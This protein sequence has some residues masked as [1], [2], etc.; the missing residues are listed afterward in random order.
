MKTNPIPKMVFPTR[1]FTG[2]LHTSSVFR[3]GRLM[4]LLFL[5]MFFLVGE[6]THRRGMTEFHG[7][8]PFSAKVRPNTTHLA[9]VTPD[10]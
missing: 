6:L 9:V 7:Y 3:Q 4:I 2:R 10:R 5:T 8:S 1:V